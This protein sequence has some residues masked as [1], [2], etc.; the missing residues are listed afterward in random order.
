MA[1]RCKQVI[2]NLKKNRALIFQNVIISIEDYYHKVP[3]Y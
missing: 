1:N 3:V 2:T